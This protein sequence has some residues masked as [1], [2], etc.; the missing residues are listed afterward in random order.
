MSVTAVPIPPTKRSVLAWI[1]VGVAAALLAALAFAY[2]GTRGAV[3]TSGTEEQF[4]AYNARQSGVTTTASGVQVLQLEAPE[5]DEKP[6]TEDVVLINY[7]GSL[8]DG[9][10][11]DASQQPTPM[12]VSGVVPGFSEGL[13]AMSKGGKYRIWIPA[14]QGYGDASPDQTRIP[15]G[16]TLI[17]DVELVDFIPAA[18]LQQ[19][20]QMQ[21]MQQMMQGGAPGGPDAPPQGAPQGE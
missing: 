7:T 3:A 4:L 6:T 19:Q 21:Q 20:M 13:Q 12:P 18:V 11:F 1:W 15:N 14:E 8:R 9:T 5:S 16:S 17:F 10:V 2:F